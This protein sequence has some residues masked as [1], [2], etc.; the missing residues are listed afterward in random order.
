MKKGIKDRVCIASR[1]GSWKLV[2]H[3]N[4]TITNE[5]ILPSGAIPANLFPEFE[6]MIDCWGV[7]SI[8]DP[9]KS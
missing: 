9:R 6:T 4:L 1:N 3:K 2:N 8:N 5:T 7:Y